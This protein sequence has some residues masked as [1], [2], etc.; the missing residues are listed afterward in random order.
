MPHNVKRTPKQSEK[1]ATNAFKIKEK[2]S[3][4]TNCQLGIKDRKRP[5]EGKYNNNTNDLCYRKKRDGLKIKPPK[6]FKTPFLTY[7]IMEC[8]LSEAKAMCS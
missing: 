8:L 5:D 7:L 2:L 4:D 6:G 1:I 3:E